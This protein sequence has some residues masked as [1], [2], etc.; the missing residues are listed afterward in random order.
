M[1][2]GVFYN[3]ITILCCETMLQ[4]ARFEDFL[5][6][7][8]HPARGLMMNG[9]FRFLRL[10]CMTKAN[11]ID[12]GVF[13]MRHM[14][15]YLGGGEYDDLCG[16]RREGNAQKLQLEELRKKYAAKILLSDINEKKHE[17]EVEAEAFRLLSL[18]EKQ[19]LEAG[20]FVTVKARVTRML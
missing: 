15:T 13:A 17:F 3:C 14:E 18:E 7:E 4:V 16:L 11:F 2:V 5:T 20:S 12:C 8:N 10:G 6:H 9:P 19:R 1:K